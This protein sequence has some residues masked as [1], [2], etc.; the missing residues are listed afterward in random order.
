MAYPP[1]APENSPLVLET[2]PPG[3]EPLGLAHGDIALRN[4]MVGDRDPIGH[5]ERKEPS[6][7]SLYQKLQL[8]TPVVE[9][10]PSTAAKIN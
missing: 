10:P 6:L 8:L 9:R 4:I 3:R 7:S 1:E 5:P 2:I